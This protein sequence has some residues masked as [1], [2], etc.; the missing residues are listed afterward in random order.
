MPFIDSAPTPDLRPDT[1]ALPSFSPPVDYAA[2]PGAAFRQENSVVSLYQYLRNSQTFPDDPNHNPLDVIRGTPYFANHA[3]RFLGSRSEGETR[4]IMGQ[5]DQE[6]A[7]RKTLDAAG[8]FGTIM[9]MVAGTV[10]PTLFIPGVT[11]AR[12]AKVARST[13]QL[14]K[15]GVSSFA[16]Q[17]GVQEGVLQATQ[18]T[19]SLSG[20]AVAVG[21]ASILGG[22]LGPA[23]G[24]LSRDEFKALTSKLDFDRQSIDAHARG[25]QEPSIIPEPSGP[26]PKVGEPVRVSSIEAGDITANTREG[27]LK[28]DRAGKYIEYDAGPILD[29]EGKE[30]GRR[31]MK[32]SYLGAR[33]EINATP[34]RIAQM[35][36]DAIERNRVE[37]LGNEANES[38]TG[39]P[40]SAGAAGA[41]TRQLDLVS[42]GGVEKL[43]KRFDPM[44]RVLNSDSVTARRAAVDLSETPLIFKENLEGI[45]TSNGPALER[46]A[47]LETT[48]AHVAVGDEIDRLFADYR[49]GAPDTAF[50]RVRAQIERFTGKDTGKMTADEFSKEISTALRSGDASAI[51][52]V[53]QAARFIRQRVFEPWKKRAI[54]AKLLPEDIDVKTA[55]SYFTRLY[56]KQRI[57]ANRPDFVDK[58]TSWLEGDQA[59]KRQAQ[60]RIEGLQNELE[61]ARTKIEK[62]DPTGEAQIAHDATRKKI[63]K[64]I[65]DWQGKSV[66]EAKS[67]M[68]AREK[69]ISE[70]AGSSGK[71]LTG[72]DSAIDRAV[73]RILKSDRNLS[74]A[75]LQARAEEITDRILSSA[76]GRLP[77]DAPMGGPQVGFHQGE[78]PRG[79]LAAREFM[80]PDNLISEYLE[81]NAEHVV[82][83]YL[84]TMVPDVM[85]A[86]RFGDVR[87]TESFKKIN[88]EYAAKV[89]GA[90]DEKGRLKIEKERQNVIRDIAAMRDRI[91]SVYSIPAEGPTKQ[92]AR[93]VAAVKNYNVLTSMGVAAMSSL[94][95]MAGTVF[96]HGFTSALSN[97]WSPFFSY[98]LRTSN[99]AVYRE[100]KSQI[101]TIG[102]AAETVSATRHRQM[103]DILDWYKPHTR[104]ERALQWGSDKFQLVNM[105]AQ[106]TDHAKT[107]ASMV[108]GA[109]I[110]KAAAMTRGG[111][112]TK[113]QLRTLA[114]SGIDA[115]LAARIAN[116]FEK[117]GGSIEQGIRFPNTADWTDVEARR[118]FEGAVGRDA[119]IA[120]VTPGQEKPLWLSTPVIS[121]LGQFK[122]FTAASTQRILIAN[123]QRRDAQVLQGLTLSMGLGMLSYW[124]NSLTGGQPVSDKP[125]DWIK[126]AISR[127]ALLGWF[128]EGNAMASK[129]SGGKLD[130]YR[131]IGSGKPMSRYAGRTA[132]DQFLG[133]TAGKAESLISVTGAAGRGDWNASDS[134]ALRRLIATQNVFYV[135]KLFD[136]VEAGGNS[137]FGIQQ[138]SPKPH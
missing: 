101:R 47:R 120:V 82:Q 51:P 16:I 69:A 68:K 43:T 107:M 71:R 6:D 4:S 19:R 85:L 75:E 66:S 53:G 137:Y 30:T 110:L 32:R 18:Q 15:E 62:G 77:Y 129:M 7:D 109:E 130:L 90:K 9:G 133:P 105:L 88:E 74:R 87:M 37:A 93:V 25:E 100:A 63:E 84:R 5:I 124:G 86:E 136:Q 81:N 64:E 42:A 114:E 103:N 76:D 20:S 94:T 14:A 108:A 49:F 91:R 54:E 115:S 23:A 31:S 72:A 80:I 33:T 106:W 113:R 70:G 26:E 98:L 122:S 79:S 96:R 132:M 126:E 40:I 118:A 35:E 60:E 111:A 13:L 112:A 2:V 22:L 121:V 102:I 24:L 131:A 8:G 21:S 3:N 123:L 97:A 48:S 99:S 61:S 128:E 119:D 46:L 56:D 67:A 117:G 116:E 57:A 45:P 104:V 39:T 95:D 134:K 59:T 29:N 41:D 58:T 11:L 78:P 127:G 73:Q 36:A 28:E 135:R 55:D 89:R 65:A 92:A 34:E 10:D 138:K 83:T 50:P 52:Q 125:Q 1:T 12:E 27:V 17:Q 44:S 38:G